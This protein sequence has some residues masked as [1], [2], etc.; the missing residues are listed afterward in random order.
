[1]GYVVLVASLAVSALLYLAGWA[2]KQGDATSVTAK[3]TT[4]LKGKKK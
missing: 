4:V 1:M 2:L 3:Q